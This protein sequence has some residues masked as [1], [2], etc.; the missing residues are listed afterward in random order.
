MDSAANSNAASKKISKNISRIAN[1][2]SSMGSVYYYALSLSNI[3]RLAQF[4]AWF[5]RSSTD[6]G[7]RMA[8]KE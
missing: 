3:T 5:V 8:Q 6:L 4:N 1:S 2:S 7:G